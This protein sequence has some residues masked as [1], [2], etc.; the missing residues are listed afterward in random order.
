MD[1]D[2]T[3]T[4]QDDTNGQ[5]ADD[6]LEPQ[7]GVL[8]EEQDGSPSAPAKDVPND[9]QLPADHPLMDSGIDADEL[10]NEGTEAAAD[11]AP[12]E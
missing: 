4:V 12:Q 1:E 9:G 11:V 10:Y 8:P 2:D 7:D 6:A 5:S 3:T